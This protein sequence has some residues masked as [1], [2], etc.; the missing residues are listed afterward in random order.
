MSPST[1]G[2]RRGG[3]ARRS[4]HT[5]AYVVVVLAVLALALSACAG[6]PPAPGDDKVSIAGLKFIPTVLTVTRGATVTWTN[7]DQTAHTIT[8]DDFPNPDFATPTQTPPPGAFTSLPLSPG[9]S[10]SHRFDNAGT[11]HYHCQIH[12]YLKGTV[13]VK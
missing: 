1:R 5:V 7:D 9:K 3:R 11:F 2:T 8:S 12:T 13:I 10:F 6:L 4:L